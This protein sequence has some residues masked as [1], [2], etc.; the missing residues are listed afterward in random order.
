MQESK[1]QNHQ[2][3]S[4][5][6]DAAAFQR[7][8]TPDVGTL[9]AIDGS[10]DAVSI[11]GYLG[12]GDSDEYVHLYKDLDLQRFVRIP[13]RAIIERCSEGDDLTAGRSVVLIQPTAL[14]HVCDVVR[15]SS[16]EVP[17][18]GQQ[19]IDWPHH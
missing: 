18:N 2:D 4:R 13:V 14:L 12:T 9:R 6:V 10:Q 16:L 11:V 5:A 15:A 3:E 8:L 17:R 1:Q 19:A 7:M